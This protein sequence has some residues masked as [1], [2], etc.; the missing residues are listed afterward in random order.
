MKIT[1]L[2][3]GSAFSDMT[4]FNSAYLVEAGE[5]CFM[6][7]CGS[8]AIRALQKAKT[9]L[10]SIDDIYLTHLHADHCAG[11]PGVL[12]AMHVIE[13]KDKVTVHVPET[14]LE[15][16]RAWLVNSF[17]YN[18]RMS[19]ETRLLPLHAGK[20]RFGEDV[21]LELAETSH[22]AKYL[23]S[24]QRAGIRPLSFSVI[25]REAGK[26]FF[27][28]SDI[29]S[30]DEIDSQLNSSLSFVEA[31]HL[32]LEEIARLSGRPSSR[33]YLTHIP[34]EL[35][36]GGMWREELSDRFGIKKLNAVYDGQVFNI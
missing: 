7:D 27:F 2:G 14:Q 9:D 36:T 21:E 35:E 15:F 13:R 26:T 17:I 33:I 8:D 18:E 3:S 30:I 1:V 29:A 4:R 20:E 28:S 23:E 5:T 6:I 31:V 24:A 32:R 25:V 12:T 10:F 16:V 11:L 22:L 34:Q 19:F